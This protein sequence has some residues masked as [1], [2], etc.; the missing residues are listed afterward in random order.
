MTPVHLEH[1]HKCGN[2]VALEG[3]TDTISTQLRLLPP[4]QKILILPSLLEK[5][6][7]PT[8]KLFNAR[9]FIREVYGLFVDRTQTARSF[10]ES[11]TPTNRKLVFMNGGSVGARTAC[12]KQI[13]GHVT[14]GGI[15]EAETIFN[16]I[17]KDGVAGLMK[18]DDIEAADIQSEEIE[19][20]HNGEREVGWMVE[21]PSVTAIKAADSLSR[22][23]TASQSQV[24]SV[25]DTAKG[26]WTPKR[27]YTNATQTASTPSHC[28]G[29]GIV[30]TVVTIPKRQKSTAV[31]FTAATV[32]NAAHSHHA[33]GE[34]HN[35]DVDADYKSVSAGDEAYFPVVF[36]DAYSIDMQFARST[37]ALR[38]AKSFNNHYAS[39]P[40]SSHAPGV[41]KHLGLTSS[42]EQLRPNRPKDQRERSSTVSGISILPQ[43]ATL[44][45]SMT[46]VK[47]SP[48]L[49]DSVQS[50]A[51]TSR[52]CIFVDRGTDAG[53]LLDG[54]ANN[55][56]EVDI[57][58][59]EPVFATVED[60]IIHFADNSYNDYNK[61][62]ENILTSYKTSRYPII[63]SVPWCELES[64]SIPTSP[65]ST[66]SRHDCDDEAGL[67]SRVTVETDNAG[68]H[69][70]HK[71]GPHSS[72]DKQYSGGKPQQ[73]D[74]GAPTAEMHIPSMTPEPTANSFTQRLHLFSPFNTTNAISIQ[75][76]FRIFL[77]LHFPAG[78]NGYSQYYFAVSPEMDRLWKPVFRNDETATIGHE[79]RTVDQIIALGCEEGVKKGFFGQVS[80][81][82]EKLGTKKSGI[83]RSGRLDLWQVYLIG[84]IL[85]NFMVDANI[86][87]AILDPL[88]NPK[89]LA[90]LI[91]PQLEAYLATNIPTRLL[92]LQ[93]PYSYL[94]TILEVQNLLGSDLL[95][96]AGIID[97]L[98]SDPRSASPAQRTSIDAIASRTRPRSRSLQ[99]KQAR[100][101]QSLKPKPSSISQDYR[102]DSPLIF[103]ISF[104]KANYL[105]PSTATD[106]EMATFLSVILQNLVE[107]S[108]YYIPEPESEP[109]KVGKIS[110]EEPA[111]SKATQAPLT[112]SFKGAASKI[113]R[114]TRTNSISA[115]TNKYATSITSTTQTTAGECVCKIDKEWENFYIAE[116]DSEDDDW[117][118]MILGRGLARIIP[119]P[120]RPKGAKTSTKKALKWLGLS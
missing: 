58:R 95:K 45:T 61:I 91:V 3:D 72:N 12:I 56:E 40:V 34:I 47:I 102:S 119:E 80:G 13:C 62:L 31:P 103:G 39:I 114:L 28:H 64:R 16:D 98:A 41:R 35:E 17:V 11:S 59:F 85:H 84:N 51:S 120:P 53:D 83:S 15:E 38:R 105:L 77:N 92:V 20:A 108:P 118:R 23:T 6:S 75:N 1:E 71:F 106:A 87:D 73:F 81:Q 57:L 21:D 107:R 37:L 8:G 63:H 69:I 49:R 110:I 10:L 100:S 115:R 116:E 74:I 14:D 2:L 82:I 99:T 19:S 48:T 43:T 113:S 93:F 70:C 96:V 52:P 30:H 67:F 27:L 5:I 97:T 29:D 90:S 111:R 7:Q 42:A 94:P 68:R 55:Q 89:L 54:P 79:G 65:K 109:S 24:D 104:S 26:I 50:F 112:S 25:G 101:S 9:A 78:E 60:I 22:T 32:Y 36:G 46:T 117:D 86:K 18:N 76:S 88:S 4:S 33:E 44:N 66:V